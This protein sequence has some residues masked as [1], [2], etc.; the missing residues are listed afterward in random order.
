MGLFLS[1]SLSLPLSFIPSPP[2][3]DVPVFNSTELF[4]TEHIWHPRIREVRP[5]DGAQS[6]CLV[7]FTKKNSIDSLDDRKAFFFL[8]PG[9]QNVTVADGSLNPPTPP[10]HQTPLRHADAR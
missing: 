5:T 10:R 4:H 1:R 2:C 6:V 8:S 7:L 3:A 9:A